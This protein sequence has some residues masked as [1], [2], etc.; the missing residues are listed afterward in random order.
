MLNINK[1]L[2][3]N[4]LLRALTGIGVEEF[5]L[6]GE[7]F[8]SV[9][10]ESKANKLR[11][12]GVG[13]GRKGSL[14][15]S[16]S[17]LF[18]ILFYLK[19]YPT[20]DLGAFI[21]EIDRSRISRW[22]NSFMPLLEKALGRT[23]KLPKRQITSVEEFFREFPEVK[24]LFIDGTERK[25]QRPKKIKISKKRYSGKK[26]THTR[27]NTIICNE[28]KQIL[29]IS[30][31]KEGKI[32]DLT[33]LKKS[34]VL[35]HLPGHINLWVDK[36]YQGITKYLPNNNAVMMPHKKPRKGKLTVNQKQEN[37][38]I[39]GIRMVVEHAIG[40]SK[41]LLQWFIYIEIKMARM[42]R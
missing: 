25:T 28:Q 42:I 18:F 12:R 8:A 29:L 27:K 36:G 3:S 16:A 15:D 20:Y 10:Y 22:V 33:Q 30:P 21:F 14:V 7:V 41:D 37:T 40:E 32:H 34:G 13:A 24:D 5:K 23:V 35:E 31:T 4:R 9:L 19:I 6:L 2:R 26:K 39:S 11:V 17:K 1:A 38:I